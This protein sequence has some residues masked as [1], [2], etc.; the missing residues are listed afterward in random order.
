MEHCPKATRW[1]DATIEEINDVI[2]F[3]ALRPDSGVV[4]PIAASDEIPDDDVYAQLETIVIA[5]PDWA[6]GKV[7]DPVQR[8]R[9][10]LFVAGVPDVF[11]LATERFIA[12][13]VFDR[14][15]QTVPK[16]DLIKILYWIAIHP[17]QGDD[18]A[19]D[20][21]QPFGISNGP[22]DMQEVRY[23]C[24]VYAVKLLGRLLGHIKP[25]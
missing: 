6:P 23:R 14:I 22:G 1:Q 4:T 15:Q 10:Y 13:L 17:E 9:N 2:D 16:D 8:V 18:K 7:A 19:V 3:K 20:E 24:A 25:R 12:Q 5:L 11:Q 21:L